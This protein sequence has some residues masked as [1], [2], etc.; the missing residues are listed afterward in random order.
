MP[1]C[2][3]AEC[4]GSERAPLLGQR[5][6]SVASTNPAMPR[7][8]VDEQ[9]VLAPEMSTTRLGLIMG[10]AWVGVF[11]MA[12][13]GTI[14]ATLAAPISSEFRSLNMLSWIATAY[15][16]SAAAVLPI[17]GRL[18]D[19]FG[20]GPGLVISNILFATGNLICGMATDQ[21][22]LLLGRALAGFGGGGLRSIQNFL[23]SDLGGVIGGLINDNAPLGW[24]LA[25]LAQVPPSLL[26]AV[27]VLFL[28]RVPP[29]QSDKSYLA[30]IDFYGVFMSVSC[31]I[32]MLLGL[33]SG[34]NLVPWSHPLPLTTIPLSVL[35][36]IGFIWWETKAFQPIIPVKLLLNR[37]ILSAALTN[38]FTDMVIM[39]ALFYMPLY[40]QV[41]GYSAT[42]AGRM[43][44]PS[45]IGDSLGAL[46]AGYFM[47]HTGKYI[48]LGIPSAML[49]VMATSFFSLQTE[50][51][52]V[53]YSTSGFFLLGSS[54]GIMLTTT[55]VACVAAVDHE[56][57]A[58]V[59]SAIFFIRSLGSTLGVTT[60]SV[61]YQNILYNQLWS[62]FGDWPDASEEIGRIR[63]HLDELKHLPDGWYDGVIRSF[64]E[65]FRGVWLM[66]LGLA[67]TA[68]FCISGMKQ[69]QLH[70]RLSR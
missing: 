13:D 10:T 64:M 51:S 34:G 11:L 22:T 41:I 17:T 16:I 15:L 53:W 66:M 32:F 44:L 39:S 2:H 31:T 68:L 24:R 3:H 18:T 45:P 60:A 67:L 19:I 36:F 46:G 42:N 12:L 65:A 20:R 30:R 37:T 54:Y 6:S 62:K 56:H 59:G 48:W 49:L 27:A 29:K 61:V 40:L 26:S 63:E 8:Q 4:N 52:P 50:T 47:R 28:V 43:I 69:H 58:V 38:F 1:R 23:A 21:Y 70:S 5:N 9:V 55:Q 33:N 35:L 14:V 57:Q 25:F 7:D